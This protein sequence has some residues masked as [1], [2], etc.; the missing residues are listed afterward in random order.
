MRYVLQVTQPLY[1]GQGSALALQ[2][3]QALIT[4]GH[5]LEQVFFYGD[6]VYHG[7]AFTYPANDEP[8]LL[9]AWQT[10]AQQHQVRLNLCVAA[11]QRRGIVAPQS[12]VDGIQNN[13][14]E[15]FEIAGLG[16]FSRAVLVADRL[17]TV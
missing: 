12:A 15:K 11:A 13:L 3:A 8:N 1:G 9:Q 14:A 4:A 17:V 2:L 16:D 6:G 7:N 10:L 5:Q